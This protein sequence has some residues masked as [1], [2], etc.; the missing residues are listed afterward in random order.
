VEQRTAELDLCISQIV[1]DEAATGDGRAAQ[2]RLPFLQNLPILDLTGAVN[3]VTKAIMDSG[4]LPQE[5]PRDAVHIA[6]SSIHG[7]DMLLTWNCRHIANAAI[8]KELRTVVAGC[9]YELPTL[10]TPEELLG[11]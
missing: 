5:A 2:K 3:D 4:L 10:C 7:I 1:L 11:D 6:V 8:M 9:G